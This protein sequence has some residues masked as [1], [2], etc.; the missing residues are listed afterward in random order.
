M[1]TTEPTQSLPIL[2]AGS[3]LGQA[4]GRNIR[5]AGDH[6]FCADYPRN[7]F[8]RDVHD[9]RSP[10]VPSSGCRVN[11][12]RKLLQLAC[13]RVAGEVEL[14]LPFESRT[15]DGSRHT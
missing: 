13:P 10:R 11:E 1:T 3:P 8:Q 5:S 7:G 2:Q 6:A 12:L 15:Q 4:T 14:L 9:L